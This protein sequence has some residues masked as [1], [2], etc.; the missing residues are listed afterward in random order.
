MQ[1][2]KVVWPVAVVMVL[3]TVMGCSGAVS[4]ATVPEPE[5]GPMPSITD[6]QVE[7]LHAM[8]HRQME[9]HN[10]GAGALAVMLNGEVVYDETFGWMDRRRSVPVPENVMMRLASIS[11][12]VTAAAIR[13]LEN[14]GMLSLSDFAFDLGQP[15]GGILD[16]DPL[17]SLGDPRLADITVLHLLQHRGGWD[18]DEVGDLVDNGN[19]IHVAEVTGVDSPPGITNHV[20]YIMGQPLQFDPGES[21]KYAN[22][23]YMILGLIVEEASG[24][25]YMTY[26]TEHIFQPLDVAGEVI[27]GRTFPYDRSAREPWYDSKWLDENPLVLNVFDPDGARVAWPDGGWHHEAKMAYGGLVASSRAILAFLE[28]YRVSGPDIGAV[29]DDPPGTWQ[30]AHGGALPGTSTIAVQ[31]TDMNYVVLFNRWEGYAHY[32]EQV[33]GLVDEVFP[34]E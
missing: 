30:W 25:D 1:A 7:A 18:R 33:I 3:V 8:M 23:G 17:P 11:K 34:L 14:D 15:R 6:D 4:T 24:Q 22:V 27:L 5:S 2:T 19:E 10:I 26:I 16:L 12:P 31:R 9:R 21:E 29:R 32:A 20:R 28:A 13:K